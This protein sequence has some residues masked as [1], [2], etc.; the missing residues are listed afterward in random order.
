M[1]TLLDL[2]ERMR[3][4]T[5]EVELCASNIAVNVATAIIHDLVEHTPVDETVAMS[6]WQ[7]TLNS[8]A[9]GVIPAY[10]PGFHGSTRAASLAETIS[11]GYVYT[12]SK[13]T[14]RNYLDCQ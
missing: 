2:A 8:R 1:A 6:N 7:L 12:A 9:G 4:I 10:S 11:E 14:R 13:A 3:Q 5:D